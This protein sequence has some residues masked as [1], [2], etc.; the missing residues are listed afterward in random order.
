MK[1]YLE[2][3]SCAVIVVKLTFSRL[4]SSRRRRRRL[5]RIVSRYR[6]G[7]IFVA[8]AVYCQSEANHE[9]YRLASA[10]MHRVFRNFVCVSFVRI[11]VWCYEWVTSRQSVPCRLCSP[12]PLPVDSPLW[13]VVCQNIC[14]SAK[15]RQI[16]VCFR[17][18]AIFNWRRLEW[19]RLH[20]CSLTFHCRQLNISWAS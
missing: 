14:W 15:L 3:D 18:A 16:H 11:L 6:L 8:V 2:Y 17:N 13:C 10:E 12:A 5:T 9:R 19:A 4:G 20:C 7:T 1:W